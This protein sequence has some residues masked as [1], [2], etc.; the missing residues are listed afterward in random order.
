MKF[1][2]QQHDTVDI[3]GKNYVMVNDRIKYLREHFDYSIENEPH[4]TDGVW[5]VKSTLKIFDGEKEYI[6]IGHAQEKI[7]D[8]F[9]NKTS[10]L[11]NAETSA[12]GRALAFAGVYVDVSIASADEII[13][14][15]N[16]NKDDALKTNIVTPFSD[17]FKKMMKAIDEG[18]SEK[19]LENLPKYNLSKEARDKL[20]K[21]IYSE[22]KDEG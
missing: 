21:K 9:I 18:K 16:Q 14:A 3:K 2:E 11:E 4:L 1:P 13:K 7:G 8:G 22:V 6:Y 20:H 17:S 5:L 12:V 19:V 10:A 15:Q